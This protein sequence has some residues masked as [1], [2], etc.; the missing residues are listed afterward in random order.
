MKRL[1]ILLI[2]LVSSLCVGATDMKDLKIYVNPGHGGHDSDDRNVT[3]P[4]FTSGDP[5]GFWESNSN[6]TKGLY[7]RDL[8]QGLGANVMMSRVTN[9]T[10]DDRGL[11]EI[12]YEA[13]DYGADFFFSIHS[14]ATGT[15]VRK[16]QPLMLFRG[17]TADPVSPEAKVMS[18]ILNKHLLEN[19]VTSW[20]S[21]SEWIAGDFNFYPDW[22]N[23]GLGVLRKLTVPG[24]LSEG[25]YHDYIPETYRLLNDEYCWLEAYHFSK[26]VMEYFGTTEKY[27]TGVVA[28]SIYDSRLIRTEEI[29][30]TYFFGHDKSKPVCG[31]TVELSDAGGAVLQTYMTDEYYNGVY[32]FKDVAPGSYKV[33]I[34]HPEYQ[35]YEASVEVTANTVTYHNVAM[36][37]VRNTAPEVVSYTPEWKEGGDP[38]LCNVPIVLN[39]NWDM[40]TESVENN[41]SITPAVAGTLR[42]EDS[43]YRLVFEPERAYETNTLYTVRLNKAAMHPGGTQ[44]ADDFEFSFK[45]DDYNTFL[46]LTH[47]PEVDGY[48]HY[49]TPTVE[50][51]FDRQPTTESFQNE[52]T[53]RDENGQTLSYSAR[54]RKF[55]TTGDYGYVSI[56][57]SDDLEP[58]KTYTVDVAGTVCSTA[59]IKI[60]APFSYTFTAVDAAA[61]EAGQET[62][63]TF[64][65]S[66]LAVDG[67]NSAGCTTWNVT[68]DK[69]TKL[70]GAAAGKLSYV[71]SGQTGGVASCK[72]AT[73]PSAAYTSA[74]VV[75]L[76]VYGDLS[77]NRLEAVFTNGTETKKATLCAMNFLGWRD[78]RLSL[79]GLLGEGGYSLSGFEIVQGEA[80]YGK[81]GDVY[82][83]LLTIWKDGAS[84]VG[85]IAAD[86]LRL[87]PNPA[88]DRLVVEADG[89]VL[90]VDIVAMD[91]RTVLSAKGRVVDVSGVAGGVYV[92]R[93]HTADGVV[94]RR[95]AVGR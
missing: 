54:T 12:G 50:F 49:V 44:M 94:S 32:L 81:K 84:G 88:S 36:D 75:G 28:G 24:M 87:Y 26:A 70:E 86:G 72:F 22:N 29:Y 38:V 46:V 91:G 2:G 19:R 16:N 57:L 83:D 18:G 82:V 31:A 85:R 92:A 52:I 74:D 64:D 65:G 59:G 3:V 14:N 35:P 78:V 60:A 77:G 79:E 40:D 51:R 90:G 23:Q 7:L 13:N 8:L 20:S 63:E 30:G 80:V 1:N 41:F 61:V 17:Y 68:F 45:T 47:S 42:W 95:I 39:F 37:R 71:F 55:S 53:V 76:K 58:G 43:Q 15:S 11:H 66:S 34:S 56:R 48:V 25:S 93:I 4:P 5:E 10:E 9:T 73:V 27:T 21:E 62:V 6:L 89:E 67:N 69:K 33:K